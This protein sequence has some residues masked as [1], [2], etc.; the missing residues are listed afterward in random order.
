MKKILV[1]SICVIAASACTKNP[2]ANHPKDTLRLAINDEPPTLDPVLVE[3][4][5]SARPVLDLFAGLVDFDQS[6]RPI[7]GMATKW[8]ISTDGKTY[9]FHLRHDLKF[10]DGSPITAADFVYSWQRMAEPKTAAPMNYLLAKVQNGQAILNGKAAITQLGVKALDAYT[11]VASLAQPDN[12]FIQYLILSSF[13]VVPQ[14]AIEKYGVKW[15]EPQNIVTSGPYV[16]KEHVV[17]G[18]LLAEKNPDY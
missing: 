15:T 13:A 14:K 12:D 3:D 1:L 17:N 8:D 6:N 9:T 5:S 10:S 7:P 2:G 16:L 11:F 18:Y 4:T